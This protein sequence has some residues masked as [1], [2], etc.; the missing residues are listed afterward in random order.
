MESQSAMVAAIAHIGPPP[1][2]KAQVRP[3]FSEWGLLLCGSS[4]T[5]SS[6]GQLKLGA[7]ELRFRGGVSR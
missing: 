6:T 5:G 7:G 4:S 1:P 3:H 2:S